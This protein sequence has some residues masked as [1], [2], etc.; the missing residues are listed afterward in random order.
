MDGGRERAFSKWL[1]EA[2]IKVC[3]C[4]CERER[5]RERETERPFVVC[6]FMCVPR[7]CVEILVFA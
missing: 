5:E 4:V 7:M 6:V 3:V 2:R 1:T